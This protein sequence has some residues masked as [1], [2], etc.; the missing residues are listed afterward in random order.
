MANPAPRS[1]PPNRA[2]VEA[3]WPAT[4]AVLGAIALYVTLPADLVLG[5][6]WVLPVLEGAILVPLTI[7]R[8]HRHA[9][10]AGASRIAAIVLIALANV[11]NVASL[12]LL[13]HQ[14]LIHGPITGRTLL[15]AAIEIY[16]TNVIIFGLWYWELDS[17][18]PAQRLAGSA[19]HPDFM[20]PQMSQPDKAPPGWRPTFLDYLY[21]SLTNA[22]AFSPTDTMPL[23]RLA[24]SLM[25][26]QAIASLLTVALVAGRAVNIL[27]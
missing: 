21:V 26:L 6:S 22:T 9:G 13:I 14:L 8:P 19:R 1:A 10:E 16:L 27:G 7:A 2:L 20:Y 4:L 15:F 12:I 3:R 5:P 25:G 11:G 18:G 23:T 17:G 24:K